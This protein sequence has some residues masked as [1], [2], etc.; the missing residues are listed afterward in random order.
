MIFPAQLPSLEEL[1]QTIREKKITT[2]WLTAGLFHQMVEHQLENLRGVKQLLAGGDVL[3]APHVL[4]ALKNLPETQLINGYGPT[5]S[6]TFTTCCAIPKNWNGASVPIGKPISNTQVFIL[7]GQLQPVPV[8]V[9]GELFIGGDGLAREYLN[10]PELTAKKFVSVAVEN[11]FSPNRSSQFRLYRTGD[12]VRWLADGTVEFLGR[13]DNQVKIRG[14]RI[15]LGEIESAL[16]Q[17]SDVRE[18]IV[19]TRDAVTGG[20]Q[21]VA[22]IVPRAASPLTVGELQQFL[23][24]KIPTFM[25]PTHFTLLEKF[26]LTANGKIDRARLPDPESVQPISSAAFVAPR[27]PVEETVAKIWNEVLVREPI[28][29]HEN[30]FE[31]G[32][33]SLL[34][35]QVMSRVARTF[36]VELPLRVLFE[37]PTIAAL[38]LQIAQSQNLTVSDQIEIKREIAP[39]A[40]EELLGR[41]DQM[42]EDEVDS[43]LAAQR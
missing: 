29:I 15:E 14:F 43:L 36:R 6:T 27:N 2:L 11:P 41:I 4:S 26:P 40:A 9:P 22:C 19:V 38:S 8:G 32:G 35:T 12:R 42:S 37:S 23:A 21:L 34:A 39:E 33:H 31:M 30:F 24:E 7:D 1:G 25:V 13:I 16:A 3:S 28:G 18:A 5:E 17:H 10:A 20:K